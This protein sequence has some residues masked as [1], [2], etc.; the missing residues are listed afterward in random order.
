MIL[1]PCPSEPPSPLLWPVNLVSVFAEA[2]AE[3]CSGG[4][5]HV[6]VVP[7]HPAVPLLGLPA[8]RNHLS[9]VQLFLGQFPLAASD[10]QLPDRNTNIGTSLEWSGESHSEMFN[11][12]VRL[13]PCKVRKWLFI[14]SPALSLCRFPHHVSLCEKD[15]SFGTLYFP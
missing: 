8:M 13:R 14:S 3:Q 6:C 7:Q 10:F 15:P 11:D 12:S 2:G 5:P 9:C 4:S 1:R